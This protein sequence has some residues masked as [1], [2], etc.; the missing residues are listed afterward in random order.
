MSIL[1]LLIIAIEGFSQLIQSEV[2]LTKEDGK[3]KIGYNGKQFYANEFIL[4][5]K[6]KRSSG[7]IFRSNLEIIRENKLGFIDVKVPGNKDIGEYAEELKKTK[8]FD[9]VEFNAYG[10]YNSFSPNDSLRSHQ[11]HLSKINTYN[12]W[13][14]TTGG[15]CVVIGIL[16][17]GIDWEHEDIGTGSDSYQ[18]IYLNPGEDAWSDVNDPTTGNGIDDDGNGFIDDWKGWN[19]VDNSNDSRSSNYHGTFVGGIVSAKTN[20]EIGIAGIAGGNNNTGVRLLPHCIGVTAPDGSILDDAIIDAVDVGVK[21]IQLSLEVA[22]SSAID[23]AIQYAIENQ[24]IVVCCS[25][26]NGSSSVSYPASNSN[27]IAVG[28]TTLNDARASF[29]NYGT[30]L[31]LVAPGV[32][33]FSTSLDDG[34]VTASGTSYAAPQ[35][36][37]VAALLFSINSNLT[38]QE[39]RNIIESTAQKVGGYSYTTTSG[40][41]NGKWNEQMGYGLLNAYAALQAVYP[42]VTGPSVVCSSGA[43]FEVSNLPGG[44]SVSWSASPSYYFATTSGT[45]STFLTAWTGGFRK[46][47]GTITATLVTSC[48]TF[49]LT[50]PV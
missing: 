49:N 2:K 8:L 22:P 31:D 19:Y 46:G 32:D 40:H 35:V 38:V 30:E 44:V 37:S 14:I 27:V 23:E 45:G 4:T 34:Y 50:K 17:S 43:T 9:V 41:P 24:V 5:V 3:Y 18:N 10:E 13:D 28:A 12:A 47:V 29:S 21:V 48:D 6:P 39:V 20:N 36:S 42:S 15:S 26:N 16:D 11:W 7:P 33:I 1:L 25:M